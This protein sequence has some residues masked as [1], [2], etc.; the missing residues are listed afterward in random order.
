MP[1]GQIRV[2][3][4]AGHGESPVRWMSLP[5]LLYGARPRQMRPPGLWTPSWFIET[6]AF[7]KTK[8]HIDATWTRFTQFSSCPA[9]RTGGKSTKAECSLLALNTTSS[10][11][12]SRVA[13]QHRATLSIPKMAE[14]RK[15]SCCR[16]SSRNSIPRAPCISRLQLYSNSKMSPTSMFGLRMLYVPPP[17]AWLVL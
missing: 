16:A 10:H 13:A 6:W 11:G 7:G 5:T 1:S 3:V 15:D 4:R 14:S 2:V 8:R 12:R 17:S 9:Y